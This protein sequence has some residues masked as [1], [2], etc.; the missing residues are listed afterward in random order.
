MSKTPAEHEHLAAQFVD[1]LRQAV[2]AGDDGVPLHEPYF[3]GQ[4][5]AYVKECLDT[6]WVSSVGSYV[7]RFE[8]DLAQACGTKHAVVLVNGT[9]ALEIALLV[10]GVVPNDEVLIPAL[11][12]VATANAVSHL[13]AHPH[14]V[15]SEGDTLGIDAAKLEAH[16]R[17]VAKRDGA[18]LINKETG[19]PIRAIV[20]MHVFGH[21]VDMNAIL[22]VSE[23]FG[24]PVVSDAAEA[25]GSEYHGAPV[26]SYG[27][28]AAI[29][30]N[31]N[32]IITTGGGGAIVTNSTKLAERAKHLS[33]T[34]K[35]PH[36]WAYTHDAVAYNYRM[37]NINAAL[38]CA[39]LEQLSG[40][41]E[42]QRVIANR[43]DTSFSD[44]DGITTVREPNR[45]KSNFWL[46]AVLLDEAQEGAR[47][48]LLAAAH[49]ARLYC[50]PVWTTLHKL[51]M[52]GS[53]PRMDL[54]TAESLERRLINI[55]SSVK[56]AETTNGH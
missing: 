22:R 14:F 56:L 12:F 23:E 36:R 41:V 51:V 37:P 24:L 34:A 10:T 11:T 19:R 39:Q 46:S 30:F 44:L 17:R 1:R 13:G 8:R 52:Y 15:D 55:P 16:L 2:G 38:G 26:C 18:T 27:D 29:S 40:F 20:P 53:S 9:A 6:G 25:L 33:T 43:Y 45:C 21:P 7:D 31:G 32:K 48:S 50:R 4:E 5:W 3:G 42:K 54:T 47:D 49:E 35:Q 28:I